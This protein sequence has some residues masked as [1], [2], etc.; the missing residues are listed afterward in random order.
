MDVGGLLMGSTW[1]RGNYI[2]SPKETPA[3]HRILISNS[4]SLVRRR[5]LGQAQKNL[6][7]D[8]V[9]LLS[10][11]SSLLTLCN[12]N[13]PM[14]RPLSQHDLCRAHIIHRSCDLD[15]TKDSNR[16]TVLVHDLIPHVL[17][18]ASFLKPWSRTTT[19]PSNRAISTSPTSS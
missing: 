9:Q 14:P 5:D 16:G 4:L 10:H 13:I 15:R 6:T 2:A 3:S 17:V 12:V 19:A 1:V 8:V 18:Y 7:V 11:N